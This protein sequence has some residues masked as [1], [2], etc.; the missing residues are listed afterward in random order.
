MYLWNSTEIEDALV[1][2]AGQVGDN[3]RDVSQCIGDQQVETR[4]SRLEPLG[5]GQVLQTTGK[6]TPSLHRDAMDTRYV[7][8]FALQFLF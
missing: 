3:I 1:A 4:E 7:C 8:I 6:L 2:Q 5:L